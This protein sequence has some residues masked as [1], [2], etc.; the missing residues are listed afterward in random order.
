MLKTKKN[1]NNLGKTTKKRL[2]DWDGIHGLGYQ[3]QKAQ[4][5]TV[6]MF[7]K[8]EE[9]RGKGNLSRV[10]PSS[11]IDYVLRRFWTYVI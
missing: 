11:W 3:S 7:R 9:F 4:T 8:T 5:L 1:K 2:D 6:N 10:H